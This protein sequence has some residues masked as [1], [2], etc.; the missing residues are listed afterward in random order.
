MVGFG[1]SAVS[2]GCFPAVLAAACF[3]WALPADADSISK[4]FKPPKTS[5]ESQLSPTGIYPNGQLFPI[6]LYSVLGNSQ[7]DPQLS[8][9][10]RVAQNGFTFAGPYYGDNWQDFGPITQ[11]AGENLKFVFQIRPPASL[12]GV[13]IDARPTALAALSDAALTASVR[14]QVAA[15]LSDPTARNTVARWSLGTA[16]LRY[17]K[18]ADNAIR[19]TEKQFGVAH[20]PF[21][22][23][24]PGHRYLAALKKTGKYQDIVGKGTYLTALPRG[25]GRSGYAIWSYTQIVS[26]ANS[27]KATPQAFL[28]LSQDF[29]DPATGNNAAEIRRVIRHDAYLGL[30]M[31]IKSIDIWSMFE[32]RPNFTTHND[33]FLAYASVAKELTGDL[34]LQKVFLFG[35]E[36]TDLKIQ[37]TSGDKQFSFTDVEGDKNKFDTLHTLNAA[38]GSDRYLF[39]VNSTEQ[40]MG[41][42]I[43][44]LPTD[45]AM[46]NL[47]A[48]TTAEMHQTKLALTLDVLGVTALRFRQV[49]PQMGG[50]NI[51]GGLS[52]KFVP[53]PPSS[54]LALLAVC[55]MAAFRRVRR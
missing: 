13:S 26:A 5:T 53:E 9:M 32:N 44:G 49:M 2:T 41:V 25:L 17:L 14:D 15:V 31:G 38:Y 47:F 23:Y 20:K 4:F 52:I 37:I 34:D 19:A 24:E 18:V 48:Q 55:S 54:V 28:Q 21:T 45:Y 3:L 7:I 33:Q 10:A 51:G 36:R 11:A 27:Q 35:D 30:V 39:L 46:D 22:M 29:T 16:E 6:G 8:N 50:G 12:S 43:T 42:N 1:R 40:T